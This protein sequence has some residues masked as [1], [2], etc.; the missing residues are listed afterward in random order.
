MYP[1]KSSILPGFPTI[2]L[3]ELFRR[4][5]ILI[6]PRSGSP[7]ASLRLPFPG[8]TSPTFRMVLARTP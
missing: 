8:R 1:L 2:Y 7:T 4:L 6:R 5:W 3:G